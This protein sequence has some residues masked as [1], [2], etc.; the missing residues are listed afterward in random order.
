MDLL[1]RIVAAI[2]G[3]PL[4]AGTEPIKPRRERREAGRERHRGNGLPAWL[5]RDR[6]PRRR[7]RHLNDTG[8]LGMGYGG[9]RTI[10]EDDSEDEPHE[11]GAPERDR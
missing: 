3:K 6:V 7:V 8:G 5:A 11:R 4:D 10:V 1:R 2:G 9:R